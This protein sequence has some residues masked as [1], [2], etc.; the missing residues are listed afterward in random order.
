MK[1]D[2]HVHTAPRSKCSNIDPKEIIAEAKKIGLDGICI[3]EHQVLW[4]T[5]E[6]SELA[7]Q[8]NIKLFRGNE[9]TTAQ[10][11][12]LVFGL[13]KNIE[14]VIPIQMLKKEVDMAGAFSILAHPFRGF[15]VFGI[16]DL[17]MSV[18]QASKKK[19]LGFVDAIEIMNGKVSGLDNEMAKNVA[20]QLGLPGTAGSDAHNLDEIGTC[21]T[22]FENKIENEQE[23]VTE[24][25]ARRFSIG[26]L[27]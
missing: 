8:E 26:S 11:D 22:I 17:K 15:K 9:I 23:L 10:G 4:S 21:V 1:I 16:S 18:E 6:I 7:G 3:T 13:E 12:V 19:A 27:R 25:R 5:E 2:L 24:L 14:G 20:E